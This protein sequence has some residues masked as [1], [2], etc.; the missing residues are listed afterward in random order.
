MNT[1][2]VTA[3]PLNKAHVVLTAKP[4]TES[5][6][7]LHLHRKLSKDAAGL[8]E[9]CG[10]SAAIPKKTEFG[11]LRNCHQARKMPER[12]EHPEGTVHTLSPTPRGNGNLPGPSTQKIERRVEGPHSSLH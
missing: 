12:Q 5:R 6:G 7:Y 10:I 3:S 11:G 1:D 4:Q 2:G 8:P 9:T